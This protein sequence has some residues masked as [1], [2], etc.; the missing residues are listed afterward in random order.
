MQ[1]NT[2]NKPLNQN[3]MNNNRTKTAK[4]AGGYQLGHEILSVPY[5]PKWIHRKMMRIFFGVKW[6]DE[7]FKSE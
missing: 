5:K 4:N 2:T 3:K 6:V 7:T 1:N